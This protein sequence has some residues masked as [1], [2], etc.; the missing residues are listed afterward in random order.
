MKFLIVLLL[1]LSSLAQKT[2]L[3]PFITKNDVVI[4][5]C[6]AIAGTADGYNQTLIH[7][8][9]GFRR[10]YPNLDEKF[11]NPKISD[12]NKYKNYPSDTR[13]AFLGSK[14]IFVFVTDGFHLTRFI[15]RSFTTFSVAISYGDIMS[16]PKNQRVLVIIKK[17]V[18]SSLANRLAFNIVY[19]QFNNN[20]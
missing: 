13:E 11:W 18:L 4:Y 17:L 7:H 19:S 14:T 10:A 3:K 1:P 5:S 12:R 8:Y 6:Q 9:N 15:D 20:K 16:Y 2:W